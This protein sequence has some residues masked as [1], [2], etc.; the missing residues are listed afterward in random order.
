MHTQ[1]TK[2]QGKPGPGKLQSQLDALK[3]RRDEIRVK[4]NLAEKD[5]RD[6]FLKI[7]PAVDKAEHE[8]K[9]MA[10]GAAG[11]VARTLDTL[12]ASLRKIQARMPQ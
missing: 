11:A 1:Y 4:I 12:A 3:T 7:V 8:V 2:T 5:V 6:A 10:K 9:H